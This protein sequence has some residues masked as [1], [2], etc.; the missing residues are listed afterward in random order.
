MECTVSY[1]N[2]SAAM[3]WKD[4]EEHG[5]AEL[6]GQP[7]QYSESLFLFMGLHLGC[8]ETF[9]RGLQTQRK[10]YRDTVPGVP[11]IQK[12]YVLH[13]PPVR[14]SAFRSKHPSAQE[15]GRSGYTPRASLWFYTVMNPMTRTRAVLSPARWRKGTIGFIGQCGL[16]D[17]ARQTHRNIR[18]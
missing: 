5:V 18:L 7:Q 1:A 12:G 16:D 4:G 6:A 2:S 15:R 3:T 8:G 14:T 11:A 17:L 13:F 10:C 9:P